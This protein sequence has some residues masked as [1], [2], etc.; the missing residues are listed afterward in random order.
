MKMAQHFLLSSKARTLSLAQVMRMSEEEAFNM[1]VALRYADNGGVPSCPKCG[2]VTVYRYATR[3]I[4][5][6]KD[7][8]AQ[9]SAT[10]G[11]IFASRKLDVRDILAAI[12]IFANGA[13][14]HSALQLSRDLDCQYRTAYVLAHKLRESMTDETANITLSG[15][16]E[17]DGAY[18]GGH[19]KPANYKEDRRDRRLSEN[20]TGKRRCV[21]V[22]R[23]RGG[24]T[25]TFV[26]KSELEAVPAIMKR[27]A[28]GTVIH[29]DEAT[30]WD[31]LG[32][33]YSMRRINHSVCYSDGQACTNGAESF[34]SRL[35]RAELGTHHSIR[36]GYLAAYAGEMAWREDHRRESNGAQF[37]GIA[38]LAAQSPVSRQWKGYWQR[39]LPK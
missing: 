24:R 25:V 39:H 34:F 22:M 11:T 16:V 35:R 3:R 8:Q 14:G 12:A 31:G 32:D 4:F 33:H 38:K 29:A 36:K 6:C 5:K 19:V 18:F 7:C 9:F 26:G 23:E 13:K 28:P 20:Q 15:T 1:F 17:I 37:M 10:S 21:T 2:S 30:S 27:V